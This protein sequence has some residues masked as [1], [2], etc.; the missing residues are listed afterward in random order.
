MEA[1]SQAG[2]QPRGLLRALDL[3]ARHAVELGQRPLLATLAP[4]LGGLGLM[5]IASSAAALIDLPG[6]S[7][8]VPRLEALLAGFEALLVVMPALLIAAMYA[9]LRMGP[10]TLAAALAVAVLAGG[11]VAVS[12][13]PLMAFLGLVERTKEG[14]QFAMSPL[15]PTVALVAVSAVTS[16]VM[17]TLDASVRSL[18]LARAFIA[19]LFSVFVFRFLAHARFVSS[20]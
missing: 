2:L 15:V 16:R 12:L 3:P 8:G 9:G 17:T 13:V 10:R 18:W 7:F 14:L 5:S 11:M 20:S 4:L 6:P 1:V 19:L